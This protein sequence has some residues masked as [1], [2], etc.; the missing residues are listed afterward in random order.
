MEVKSL[1][2]KEAIE[3]V[4]PPDRDSGF[5]S[6]HFIVP[7]KEGGLHPILDLCQFNHSLRRYRFKIFTLKRIVTQIQ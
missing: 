4:P 6:Q 2:V 5:Y 3:H 1:L 7:K